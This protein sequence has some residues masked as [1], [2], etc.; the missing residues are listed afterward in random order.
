MG[1]RWARPN[2]AQ[3]LGQDLVSDWCTPRWCPV[4][5]S[6]RPHAGAQR[7]AGYCRWCAGRHSQRDARTIHP[8]AL[9]FL[10]RAARTPRGSRAYSLYLLPSATPALIVIPFT[11]TGV[12]GP[13]HSSTASSFGSSPTQRILWRRV[14]GGHRLLQYLPG[15]SA[16]TLGTNPANGA[17]HRRLVERPG[18]SSRAPRV[19][20]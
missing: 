13:Q 11:G 3:D 1:S 15:A 5:T 8:F 12:P 20:R 14:E 16:G 19:T 7:L 6:P 4:S 18:A 9:V 10:R 2:S 17:F